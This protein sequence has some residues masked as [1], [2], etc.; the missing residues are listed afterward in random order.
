MFPTGMALHSL[1]CSTLAGQQVRGRGRPQ[2]AAD[3]D[4]LPLRSY[5]ICTT[6]R[7]GS[8]LLSDGLA[9]TGIAGRPRE[10]F[11]PLQ[12]QQICARWRM[13]HDSDLGLRR[14]LRVVR[15]QSATPNG[16]SGL[17]LH[18]Y[19]FAALQKKFSVLPGCKGLSSAQ[20][21]M[22]LYP[23]ARYVWLTRR[24][25]V[26][27]AVSFLQAASTDVWWTFDRPRNDTRPKHPRDD[28]RPLVDEAAVERLECLFARNDARWAEFFEQQRIQPFRIQYE[29]FS[30]AYEETIAALLQWLSVP[31]ATDAVIP[32]PRLARQFDP[33]N[34]EWIA[35]FE[36]RRA[37]RASAHGPPPVGMESP[38]QHVR[39]QRPFA[40]L[41]PAWRRWA[42]QCRQRGWPE[43]QIARVL[44]G[45][46]YSAEQ[47]QAELRA[48]ALD[49]SFTHA[50]GDPP[51]ALQPPEQ[52]TQP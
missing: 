29:D 42:A 13:S 43:D 9:S 18:Y 36:A 7:S 52:K 34:E 3:C 26:R 28:V 39:V 2:H 30:S 32:P 49:P 1:V 22:R 27:Q 33:R 46:G 51:D 11:N 19:Q 21:L 4:A 25:K 17:K 40:R 14:Y 45:H 5:I 41:A 47:V 10:W 50:L 16:V 48:A 37:A 35:L 44:V 31:G 6:P 23:G 24:D 38:P 12:E 8:W 15:S 20:L